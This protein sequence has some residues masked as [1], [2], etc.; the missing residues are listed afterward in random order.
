MHQGFPLG[1]DAAAAQSLNEHKENTP[2]I[3]GGKGEQIGQAQC[4]ADEGGGPQDGKSQFPL[5][6]L[7]QA[8][9]QHFAHTDDAG[10]TSLLRGYVALSESGRNLYGHHYGSDRILEPGIQ[11]FWGRVAPHSAPVRPGGH[12]DTQESVPFRIE[13]W[14]RRQ[15][16]SFLSAQDGQFDGLIWHITDDAA[17][18]DQ[19]VLDALLADGQDNI[20]GSQAGLHGGALRFHVRDFDHP[21]LWRARGVSADDQQDGNDDIEYCARRQH[22]HA[23]AFGLGRQAARVGRIFL[24]RH[25]HERAHR[26][27]VEAVQGTQFQER[28]LPP[29]TP[30]PVHTLPLE[31]Q[32]VRSRVEY[33]QVA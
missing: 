30:P 33:L 14:G 23:P 18:V 2:P 4:Q 31:R 16:Q 3:Q 29:H 8:D 1:R 28:D 27:P 13:P 19:S 9:G 6:A 21:R 17:Q 15:S 32:I 11:R 22:R 10:R 24:T 25:P 12:P 26:Q 20:I 5:N 7:L